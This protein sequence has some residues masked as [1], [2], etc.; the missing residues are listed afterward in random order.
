MGLYR[1]FDAVVLGMGPKMAIRFTSFEGFKHLG[2][3][4]TGQSTPSSSVVFLAGLAAGIT[5][6]VCVVNP[7]EVVKIR[8]QAQDRLGG[9]SCPA[10]PQ[11]RNAFDAA[12]SVVRNEGISSLWRGVSLTATRQG[13]NQAANFTTYSFLKGAAQRHRARNGIK[14][15]PLPTYVTGAIGLFSG[16]MGPLCNA[17]IDTIKTRL[18]SAGS[19][20]DRRILG[21]VTN[22]IRQEGPSALY[23]GLMPRV[24][25]VAPGQA[26]TFMAYEF[27]KRHLDRLRI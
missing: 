6:S 9:G 12:R 23:K 24:M 17:P 15:G 5:E 27:F 7:M 4:V 8:L 1:G 25:R 13:T 10:V 22:L 19:H 14:K 16:A 20:G 26:V 11:Y 21:I 3:S 2:V 18:Q